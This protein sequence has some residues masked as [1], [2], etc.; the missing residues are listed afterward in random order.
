MTDATAGSTAGGSAAGRM[1][2]EARDKAQVAQEKATGALG[3][4]RGRLRE[5]VDQRST[6]ASERIHT[7]AQDVRGV[8]EALRGQDNAT[9]AK[10]ADQMADRMESFGSY[11][12]DADGDQLLDDVERL[13]RR[14][15]WAIAT[16]G[17]ALGFVASRALKASSSRRYRSAE[18]NGS[19]S[20]NPTR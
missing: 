1:K 20:R 17:L 11:L 3:Q 10:F 12:R 18:G 4:A 6:Q 9:P 19:A 14:Q 8:A 13:A 2:D 5:E 15:P 7:T 16:A